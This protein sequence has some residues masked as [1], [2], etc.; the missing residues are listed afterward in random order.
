MISPTRLWVVV[1]VCGQKAVARVENL[2]EQQQD[3]LKKQYP[4][5]RLMM[6]LTQIFQA[7]Q[8]PGAKNQHEQR[9][10][11]SSAHLQNSAESL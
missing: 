11:P 7:E 8:A 10:V 6:S 3:Q 2:L 5:E 1:I 4:L 9:D